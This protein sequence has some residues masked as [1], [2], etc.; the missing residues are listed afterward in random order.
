M[1]IENAFKEK[2]TL[3]YYFL[4]KWHHFSKPYHGPI[5]FKAPLRILSHS[6]E[7]EFFQISSLVFYDLTFCIVH[8]LFLG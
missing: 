2:Q 4:G 3:C 7:G 6:L 1:S 8:K 5:H